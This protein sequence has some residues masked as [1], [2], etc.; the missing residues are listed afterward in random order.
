MIYMAN[1]TEIRE[2][3]ETEVA[4]PLPAAPNPFSD[5]LGNAISR[6]NVRVNMNHGAI[7]DGIFELVSSAFPFDR[8]LSGRLGAKLTEI[9]QRQPIEIQ[10]GVVLIHDRVEGIDSPIVCLGSSRQG[11]RISLLEKPVK[12]I[13]VIFV[14]EL[15][16]PEEHL[17]FLG[18][19]AHLFKE[20]DL[21]NRLVN[22]EKP[23]D[24]L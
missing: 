12:V 2:V 24:I 15:E 11:F 13:I 16:S 17:A 20:K 1:S 3:R 4:M 18:E 9:V 6:G 5:I 14:P 10:Q 19:I 21:A 23:E 8:K 22:A 7:A